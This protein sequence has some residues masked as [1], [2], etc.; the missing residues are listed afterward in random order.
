[1]SRKGL[2]TFVRLRDLIGSLETVVPYVI[3]KILNTLLFR[4]QEGISRSVLTEDMGIKASQRRKWAPDS[5]HQN[6]RVRTQGEKI[7]GFPG[8]SVPPN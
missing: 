2:K 1:M 7:T 8:V 6:P 4:S 3:P 5:T